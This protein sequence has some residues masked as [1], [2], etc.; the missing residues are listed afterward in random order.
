MPMVRQKG[1]AEFLPLDERYYC[2]S[3]NLDGK[4][5]M[6]DNQK[7]VL[8]YDKKYR[9][10]VHCSGITPIFVSMSHNRVNSHTIDEL[11]IEEGLDQFLRRAFIPLDEKNSA[12]TWRFNRVIVRA[13]RRIEKQYR[14]VQVTQNRH[15]V[16]WA[17]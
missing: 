6:I 4:K 8:W 15:R 13:P 1:T 17:Y 16:T 9:C 14:N 11:I 10:T 12:V 2:I 7:A 3:K 5:F